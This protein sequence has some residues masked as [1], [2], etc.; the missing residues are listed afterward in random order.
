MICSGESSKGPA[1]C[2]RSPFE[3]PRNFRVEPPLA[4]TPLN[5]KI[6]E[7]SLWGRSPCLA[8]RRNCR[9]DQTPCRAV[10]EMFGRAGAGAQNLLGHRLEVRS[11]RVDIVDRVLQLSGE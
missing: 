3:G 4:G 1:N 11:Q 7:A 10:R 6:T 5:W 2:K 9:Q 8:Q